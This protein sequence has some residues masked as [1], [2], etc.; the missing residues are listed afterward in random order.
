MAITEVA[1]LQS[2][3]SPVPESLKTIFT[4]NSKK[5]DGWAASKPGLY[6]QGTWL[7][8]QT[9]DPSVMMMPA[10]WK[11][12]T[13]YGQWAVS[14]EHLR[15]LLTVI[16]HLAIKDGK[17]NGD[18]WFL[19]RDVFMSASNEKLEVKGL[20]GDF[21][22]PFAV[23]GA[24]KTDLE[25]EPRDAEWYVVVGWPSVEK[26]MDFAKQESFAKYRELM[27]FITHFEVR[28]YRR[29]S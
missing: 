20:L 12:K 17:P 28:H 2:S 19:E 8:Q 15:V 26:H 3:T 6:F 9:G 29:F 16:P 21:A 13:A 1:V 24:W 23:R 10:K 27:G 22:K 25:D 7:F 18:M 11:N 14:E 5:I 4:E